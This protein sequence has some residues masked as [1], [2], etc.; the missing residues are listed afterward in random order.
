MKI[1]QIKP[2]FKNN[3]LVI[4]GPIKWH[5]MYHEMHSLVICACE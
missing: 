1:L 3:L 2:G 4:I 5:I